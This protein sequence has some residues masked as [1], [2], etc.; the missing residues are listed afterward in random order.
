VCS[1]LQP[2]AWQVFAELEAA[3]QQLLREDVLAA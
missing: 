1:L 3:L 2:E